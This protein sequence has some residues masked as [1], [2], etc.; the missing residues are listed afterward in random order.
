MGIQNDNDSTLEEKDRSLLR[1]IFNPHLSDRCDEGD[2]FVPPDADSSY[3]ESL[4]NLVKEEETMQSQRRDHFFNENFVA[5][6]PGALFPSSWTPAYKIAC[7]EAPEG[8]L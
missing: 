2:R 8:R 5:E 1:N 7:K 6:K 3:V 4:R